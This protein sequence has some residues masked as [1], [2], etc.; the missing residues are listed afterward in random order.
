MGMQCCQANMTEDI[1]EDEPNN[2]MANQTTYIAESPTVMIVNHTSK[3]YVQ[4]AF[5]NCD[6]LK[7]GS[8][9]ISLVTNKP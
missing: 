6:V 1:F 4:S 2:S 8:T 3:V 5:T 7:T 9:Q